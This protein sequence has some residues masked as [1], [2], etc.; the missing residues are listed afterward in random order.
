MRRVPLLFSIVAI[1]A[2]LVVGCV[3]PPPEPGTDLAVAPTA[4]AP[5]INTPDAAEA[6]ALTPVRMGIQPWI[7][8]G[9]WWI[10]ADRGFFTAAGLDVTL[11]DFVTDSEVNAAFAAGQM[12]VANLGTQTAIKLFDNGVDLQVVLM[13]DTSYA[14]DAMLAGADIAD[15]AALKGKSVAYE[16][17]ATSELLLDAALK[18]NGMTIADITPVPMP[19]SDAGAAL[20]AGQVDAAVTYEPYISES[21]GNDPAL[22]VIYS[23]A[24]NPGLIS[25]MLAVNAP[26]ANANEETM[27]K[28][29]QTWSAAVDF[30][31]VYPD[32]GRAI[33]AEAVGSTPEE[34]ASAFEGIE[35]YNL[36]ENL[37]IMTG[38]AV[39][40]LNIVAQSAI[41]I[42]LI[43][44]AP[45]FQRMVNPNFLQ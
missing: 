38:D 13:E 41:S 5:A 24:D 21:M 32:D 18:A 20:I 42:G 27:R 45:D 1:F 11:I 14:A 40:N 12:D 28:L 3:A 17:G 35:F 6:A 25:D 34:L 10:A 31:R 36:D 26:Y 16:E 44:Q 23:G 39:E 9:P 8:Y 22:H 43:D 29:L 37:D 2:L 15:V 7:G 19:A 30:L 4:P 33:I